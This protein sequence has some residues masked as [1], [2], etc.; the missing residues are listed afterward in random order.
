MT[1]REMKKV[2]ADRLFDM[3]MLKKATPEKREQLINTFINQ[4]K[5]SMTSEEVALVM[6]MVENS[7]V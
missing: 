6:E 5:A 7:E 3:S 1:D 4:T 2:Q